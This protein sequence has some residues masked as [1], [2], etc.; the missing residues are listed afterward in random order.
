MRVLV[1]GG[2]GF[3]GSHIVDRLVTDGHAVTVFDNFSSRV[4]CLSHRLLSVGWNLDKSA[5]PDG[6]NGVRVERVSLEKLNGQTRQVDVDAVV[7]AA[8]YP[9]LRHNWSSPLERERL[10]ECN[11][12]ATLRLLEAVPARCP[13]VYLS[14]AA[15]YG[16]QP[17]RVC[18][19]DDAGVATCE[20]PYAA[21]KFAGELLVAAYAFKRGVPW[22][23]LRLVNVVGARY[24]RGVVA[25]FVEMMRRTGRI[26]AADDGRQRK[27]WVHVL[28]VADA[29]ARCLARPP[30]AFKTIA[31][32]V[33]NGPHPSYP[34]EV[35]SGVYN[36]TSVDRISW[37][38]V[39]DV[40]GIPR[41][42]VTHEARDRGAVGD[43]FDLHVSGAKLAPYFRPRRHVLI[44]GVHDALHSLGWEP[45]VAGVA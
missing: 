34:V 41:Q 2:C 18:G 42:L 19:E 5:A 26:H 17:G 45:E 1:T 9:E 40:M 3:V 7:H 4:D 35:P 21:T 14:T 44:D 32:Q 29:V 13:I 31:G 38:D 20:S 24:H 23:V 37:W 10:L 15:V 6:Y 30:A 28:D 12:D 39:V 33:G 25:D 8:A 43:P 27:S 11:V 22:H 36:V 16:A